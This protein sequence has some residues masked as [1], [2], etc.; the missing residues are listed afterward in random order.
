MKFHKELA[1]GSRFDP[2]LITCST[3]AQ[4]NAE[5]TSMQTLKD[6]IGFFPGG[7]HFCYSKCSFLLFVGRECCH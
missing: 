2:M 3:S 7:I 1:Q 4:T 5:P 6:A